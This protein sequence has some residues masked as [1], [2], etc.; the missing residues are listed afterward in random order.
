[1]TISAR[2]AKGFRDKCLKRAEAYLLESKQ[3]TGPWYQMSALRDCF[4]FIETAKM[5]QDTLEQIEARRG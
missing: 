2:E 3:M 5:W 4:K 1:M